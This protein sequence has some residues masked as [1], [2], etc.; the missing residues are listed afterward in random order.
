MNAIETLNAIGLYTDR[1]KSARYY[2]QEINQ[3]VNDAIDKKINSITDTDNPNK[4]SGI[5][6]IQKFR[7]ELYTLIKSTTPAAPT[8]PTTIT[9]VEGDFNKYHVNFPTDYRTYDRMSL[10]TN[11]VTTYARDT[12]SNEIGP[13]LDCSFRCPKKKKIYFLEDATGLSLYSADVDTIS[14]V[15]LTYIKAPAAFSIGTESNLINEG[16]GVLTISTS[17]TAVEDSV[18]NA[19]V[20]KSGTVFSTNGALTDLT[21]GQVILT[22]LLTPIELPVKT[23]DDIC[24]MAAAILLGPTED[25]EKS[26]FAEKESE[27]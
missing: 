12:T 25:F 6:R 8:G 19:I 21:S 15:T 1:S 18:Y 20:R 22:S 2:F 13:L 9:T 26:A 16:T 7:D 27:A 10:I 17:Y 24:K 5:D 4:V 3:A 11:S 23:H 14:S